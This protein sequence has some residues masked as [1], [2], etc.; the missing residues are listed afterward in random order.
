MVHDKEEER[1]RD[2]C[3]FNGRLQGHLQVS[4][5]FGDCQQTKIHSIGARLA[6]VDSVGNKYYGKLGTQ[7]KISPREGNEFIY[8]SKGHNLN[9]GQR[10]WTTY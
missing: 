3:F 6:G 10:D 4:R 7:Y 2:L 9:P 8:H 1:S 5:V